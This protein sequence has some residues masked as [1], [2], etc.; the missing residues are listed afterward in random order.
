MFFFSY[1]FHTHTLF[2]AVLVLYLTTV[3][4]FDG[5]DSTIIYHGFVFLAYFMPLPGA[6]LADSYW[7]KF[8]QVFTYIRFV[9]YNYTTFIYSSNILELTIFFFF[10]NQKLYANFKKKIDIT[11]IS[12]TNVGS[13]GNHCDRTTVH[14]DCYFSVCRVL[15]RKKKR[16]ILTIFRNQTNFRQ[17]QCVKK[18]KK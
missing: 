11:L 2:S 13:F 1:K 5:D 9:C 7:G 14:T 3:L 15:C 17:I 4:K 10:F 6:I 16:D 8:K 18:N 12:T